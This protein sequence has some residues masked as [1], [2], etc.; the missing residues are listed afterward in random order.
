MFVGRLA[1]DTNYLELL[2]DNQAREINHLHDE[3]KDLKILNRALLR[4]LGII[5]KIKNDIN[6]GEMLPI[7]GF[8]S[9]RSRIREAEAMS[10]KEFEEIENATSKEGR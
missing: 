5:D 6:T 10:R 3:I 1:D 8:K 9:T 4:R 2:N 7:G